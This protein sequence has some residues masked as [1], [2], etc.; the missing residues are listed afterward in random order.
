MNMKKISLYCNW[1]VFIDHDGTLW[2]P[3]V[4]ARYIYALKNLEFGQITLISKISPNRTEEHDHSFSEGELQII[5]IPFFTSYFNSI[6]KLPK[7]I[8]AFYKQAKLKTNYC[9]IRTYEP[10]IWILILIQ[11]LL[12]PKTKLFMHYI[13]D[14]K[15]AIFS[16]AKSSYLKKLSRFLIFLPEYYLTNISALLCN[17]SS[18]G[19]VPIKNT[20]FFIRN[21]ISEVI[22]SA[23]LESD[24]LLASNGNFNKKKSTIDDTISILYVGYI[25]PSKGINI[26]VDAIELLVKDGFIN[27]KVTVIGNGEYLDEIKNIV[28]EKNISK[29]F[30]FTGYIPFSENLF[31]H[32]IDS[33]IFINLSPSETGPRVLLEAGIFGCQLISTKVGYAERILRNDGFLIDINSSIQ[34]K[35]AIEKTID[36]IYKNKK[37]N[38]QQNENLFLLEY[39]TE[40]FFKKV[41]KMDEI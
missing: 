5:P 30:L 28:I 26:L 39:T 6:F 14:P 8:A 10:F 9:Y 16:N 2:L 33:D 37:N 22:E 41:L 21:R 40:N 32:Y 34:A 24:L 1:N 12:S 38:L 31:Y 13:S 27:F 20:P 11:K 23:M 3:S 15:S 25:R 7:F 18:N 4:H 36:K 29:Y 35:I 17:L 19:P